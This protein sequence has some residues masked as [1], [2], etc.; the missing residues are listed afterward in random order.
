MK[1]ICSTVS[2][3]SLLPQHARKPFRISVPASSANLG[4]GFDTAGLALELRI[5]ADVSPANQTSWEFSG[6]YAPTHDG[7]RD[8]IAR[9][10]ARVLGAANVPSLQLRIANEIPLGKGLGGSAAGAVLGVAIG[11]HLAAKRPSDDQLAQIITEIE[12]HPDNGLPAFFGGIVVA[13]QTIGAPPSY[14][15]IAPPPQ[16]RAVVVTPQIEMPTVKARAILPTSYAKS[17]TVFNI[18]RACL[19]GA[20]LAAGR[21]DLL[22]VAMDDRIHQ[23]YRASFVPGLDAMLVHRDPVLLGVALSGAGPSVI[24]L[25]EGD[26]RSIGEAFVAIFKKHGVESR[27]FDLAIATDGVRISELT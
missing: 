22:R 6:S 27:A 9:G 24:A 3:P 10:I 15:R 18:Q 25:V 5:V 12:G 8:E 17:D 7:L 4:P 14:V 19:L 16:M 13:A 26:G 23:P 11:A 21:I 20:A 1:P 2:M